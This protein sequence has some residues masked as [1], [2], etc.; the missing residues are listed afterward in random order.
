[1]QYWLA[2]LPLSLI[3][4]TNVILPDGQGPGFLDKSKATAKV[5]L[6]PLPPAMSKMLS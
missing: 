5:K 2:V 6:A 1:M 3:T 4:Q